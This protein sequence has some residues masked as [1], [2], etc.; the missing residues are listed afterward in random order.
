MGVN[1]KKSG[2]C[3]VFWDEKYLQIYPIELPEPPCSTH[4][5]DCLQNA[6]EGCLLSTIES[7]TVGKVPHCA[8]KHAK[9]K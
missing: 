8:F 7:E 3:G 4:I 9:D 5:S 1:L 2:F 6:L